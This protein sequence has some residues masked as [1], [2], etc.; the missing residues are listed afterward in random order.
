MCADPSQ[1]GH[2]EHCAILPLLLLLL[3]DDPRPNNPTERTNTLSQNAS[4]LNHRRSGN[5]TPGRGQSLMTLAQCTHQY[6]LIH[7]RKG[8][9]LASSR[10]FQ[11]WTEPEFFRRSLAVVEHLRTLKES[12][13]GAAAE[14]EDEMSSD[15]LSLPTNTRLL[16]SKYTKVI[17]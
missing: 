5:E 11:L 6:Q 1:K 9:L 10:R 4:N 15:K 17:S 8:Y 3:Q 2:G 16:S 12:I 13:A 14:A 7:P